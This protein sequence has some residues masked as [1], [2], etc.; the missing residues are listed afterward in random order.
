MSLDGLNINSKP[1]RIDIFCVVCFLT[2]PDVAY[3]PGNTINIFG[4]FCMV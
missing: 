2:I 3:I 1:I 4:G